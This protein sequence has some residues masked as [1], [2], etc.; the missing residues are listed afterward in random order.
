MTQMSAE[1]TKAFILQ[2]FDTLFNKRDYVKAAEFWSD[3]YIQHSAHIPP[4][5]DGLFDLVRALPRTLRYENA[6]IFVDADRAIKHAYTT[7]WGVSWRMLGGLIMVHGDDRGLRIPPKMAQ[8]EAVLIP[9]VRSGDERAVERCNA[10]ATQ[11]S[12]AGFRVRVD[13]RDAQQGWKYSEWDV[14]GVPVRIEIGP[15]DVDTNTAVLARRDRNRDE[16]G[17]RES[18]ELA[19]IADALRKKL[20]E[21]Q[22]ALYGQAKSFLEAHTFATKDRGEFFELCKSRAGM[23]DIPWC[24]RPECEAAVKAATT[25]TTRVLRPLEAGDTVCI[26]DWLLGLRERLTTDSLAESGDERGDVRDAETGHW[27]IAGR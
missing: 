19:D 10:L 24:E 18:V 9:I 3:N 6:L 7:S 15:R 2:A 17:Q 23:I 1:E 22:L 4:G 14:R 21:I 16:P 13:A 5:R 25:A 8:I 12:A 27:V 11:L 26:A 20:D